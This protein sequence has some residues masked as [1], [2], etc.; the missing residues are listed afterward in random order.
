VGYQ[1]FTYYETPHIDQIAREEMDFTEAYSAAPV[2]PPTRASIF[3]GNWRANSMNLLKTGQYSQAMKLSLAGVELAEKISEGIQIP[4]LLSYAAI[5]AAKSG[6][7]EDA[8]Q[9]VTR[10]E[11]E[12]QRVGHPLGLANIQLA[13]AEILLH[14][15]RVEEAAAP[16]RAALAFGRQLNLG[17]GLQR[18]LQ[19]NSEVLARQM[20]MDEKSADEMMQQSSSLVQRSASGWHEVDYLLTMIRINMIR[21]KF[22]V[23]RASL[24]KARRLYDKL[25][26]SGG[27]PEF[28]SLDQK[29]EGMIPADRHWQKG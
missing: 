14:L 28:Q 29:L 4:F 12:G 27:T 7:G 18:A 21:R 10:G 15:S 9:L 6:R 24:E 11:A 16:A 2:C 5:G 19:V 8:L 17:Y 23:A 20:P 22:D 25:G 3:T 13:R 26:L 1:G